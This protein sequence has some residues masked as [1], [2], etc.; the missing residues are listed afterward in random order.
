MQA[1]PNLIRAG[2]HEGLFEQIRRD[3]QG[4]TAVRGAPPKLSP[5]WWPDA[6]LTHES[7]DAQGRLNPGLADAPRRARSRE[8][9]A[10]RI[11][12]DVPGGPGGSRP[13]RHG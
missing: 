7:F 5:H 8:P 6:V 10:R 4:V 1:G 12:R 9:G 11:A 3:R 2:R 13:A